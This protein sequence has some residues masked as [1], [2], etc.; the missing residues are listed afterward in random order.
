M[1]GAAEISSNAAETGAADQSQAAAAT[2]AFTKQQAEQTYNQQETTNKA[3]Y[4]EAAA[5]Q[6]RLNSIGAMLGLPAQNIPPFVPMPDPN[7]TGPTQPPA[8]APAPLPGNS[9]TAIAQ[10][11]A[12]GQLPQ[13]PAATAASTPAGSTTPAPSNANPTDPAY[14]T[15]QLQQ[16]YASLGKTPTGPGSG[17]T[18]IAYM[19]N[20]IAA[21][22]GWTGSNAAYWTTK[23]S[24]L[25]QGG[26]STNAPSSTA[27][28]SVASYLSAPPSP[29]SAP[30]PLQPQTF[31]PQPYY[32]PQSVDQYLQNPYGGAA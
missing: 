9:P 25:V 17:P 26:G 4:G 20:Q 11:T 2:L 23:I 28:K 18:D 3:N 22:G 27:P 1:V 24:G 14:I 21:T 15:Q 29:A 12:L 7:F 16:L 30:A 8:G 13:S 10:R 19:A 31:A 5:N 6:Q 32:T